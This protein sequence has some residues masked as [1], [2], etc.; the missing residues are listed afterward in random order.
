MD[1][2]DQNW[3]A[4]KAASLLRGEPVR[5]VHNPVKPDHVWLGAPLSALWP[6][7][8]KPPLFLWSGVTVVGYDAGKPRVRVKAG[9]R[10]L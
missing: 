5:P 1:T 7:A 8:P 2:P 6:K 4:F 3:M 9:S 10:P